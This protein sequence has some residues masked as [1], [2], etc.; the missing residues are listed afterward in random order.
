M[1][2][3]RVADQQRVIRIVGR[4]HDAVVLAREIADAAEHHRLIAEIEARGRLVHHQDR[5]FLRERARNQGE[6]ALAAGD[7]GVVVV[8][9]LADAE[10]GELFARDRLVRGAGAGERA[11][12]ARCGPS[13]RRRAP[14]RRTRSRA[15][16]AHRPCG[17]RSRP[18]ACASIGL[19]SS[20]TAPPSA[21][22]SPSSV[23]NSVVLPAPFGP[24]RHEHL[25]RHRARARCSSRP[26]GCGSRSRGRVLTRRMVSPTSSGRATAARGRTARRA[27]R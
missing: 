13:A 4:E 26:D 24:S 6:L 12:A 7:A 2:A 18:G 16:A 1:I 21:R 11:S 20:S 3:T 27:R 25:A 14:C 22:C 5:R 8:L 9:Q 15:P 19:S 23:R 17:A 10:R